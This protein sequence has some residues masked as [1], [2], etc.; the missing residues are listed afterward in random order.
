[1]MNEIAR[2]SARCGCIHRDEWAIGRIS[3]RHFICNCSD[4][5]RGSPSFP[6]RRGERRVSANHE[7]ASRTQNPNRGINVCRPDKLNEFLGRFVN[8]LGAAVHAGMPVIMNEVLPVPK[9]SFPVLH[10]LDLGVDRFTTGIRDL[11][12][13]V[14]HRLPLAVPPDAAMRM[15]TAPHREA[16]KDTSKTYGRGYMKRVTAAAYGLACYAIFLGTSLYAIGFVEN[17]VVPKSIDSG[18]A[19][20]M[21]IALLVNALLLGLF[22]VQHSGMARQSFKAWWTRMI[23]SPVERST[24]VLLASLSLLLLYWQWRPMLDVVWQL[25][26]GVAVLLQAVSFAGWAIVLISTLL[27]SHVD[28]FGLAKSGCTTRRSHTHPSGSRLRCFTNLYAT[29]STWDSCWRSGPHRR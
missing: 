19:K 15:Y 27:I 28:L 6:S 21:G 5:L 23:P 17:L 9:A 16:H 26:G 2:D 10:P 13:R 7:I 11:V 22:A 24:C 12:S 18:A 20:P 14:S 29:R 25:H 4:G 3:C 8:G 1:M